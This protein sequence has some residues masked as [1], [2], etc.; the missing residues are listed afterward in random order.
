MP[1]I[2]QVS[3]KL[4]AV[5]YSVGEHE[6]R[7]WGNW[8]VVDAGPTFITKRVEVKPGQRLSLQYHEHRSEHWVIVA[9]IGEATVDDRTTTVKPGDYVVIPCGNT[10]RIHN[11]GET[12]L[13]FV[14][15]QY[16]DTLDE[17]DIVRL[18]D[19]YSRIS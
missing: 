9:G 12:T 17:R 7:P 13:I 19:D 16:G 2:E 6:E 3:E 11:T 14:E 10:H 1:M 15:V 4:K 5:R 8:R 18:Q